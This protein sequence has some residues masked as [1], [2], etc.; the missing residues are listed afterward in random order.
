MC[1]GSSLFGQD[2]TLALLQLHKIMNQISTG[3]FQRT[4]FGSFTDVI[5]CVNQKKNLGNIKGRDANNSM[6]F[7]IIFQWFEGLKLFLSQIGV[8][9]S[10]YRCGSLQYSKTLHSRKALRLHSKNH[11]WVRQRADL[12]LQNLQGILRI[13]L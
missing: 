3:F 2:I 12:R 5:K 9:W 13:G 10:N 7:G 6:I 1:C 11:P 8:W 4:F